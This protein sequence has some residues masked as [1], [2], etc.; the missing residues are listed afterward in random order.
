MEEYRLPKSQDKR[1]ALVLQTGVDG[2]VLLDALDRL[3][4]PAAADDV[5]Y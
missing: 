1:L 2:F 3:L 4:A 5:A